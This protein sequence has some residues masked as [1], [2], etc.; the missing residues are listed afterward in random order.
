MKSSLQIAE[1]VEPYL[2]AIKK[3][4]SD[5][6]DDFLKVK[7][8]LI[9]EIGITSVFENR[10]YCGIIHE[11]IQHRVRENFSTLKST[12]SVGVFNGVFGILIKDQCFIRFKKFDLGQPPSNVSTRQDEEFR[13]QKSLPGIDDNIVNL[14]AG[15]SPDKLWS[16]IKAMHIMCWNDGFEWQIDMNSVRIEQSEIEFAPTHIQNVEKQVR[17]VRPK[18]SPLK[19]KTK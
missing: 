1:S 16:S 14:Y 18:E 6:F 2:P 15:Y 13:S 7:E 3:S 19:H 9:S 11:L 4:M 5:A 8:Y 10:T 12:T 17:A